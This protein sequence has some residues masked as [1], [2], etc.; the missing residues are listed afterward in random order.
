MDNLMVGL[1]SPLSLPFPTKGNN[2]FHGVTL[3]T[4]SRL[5]ADTYQ[6]FNPTFTQF[7]WVF[8]FLLS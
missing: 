8:L 7:I 4:S 5:E 3:P 6:G 2:P 1:V